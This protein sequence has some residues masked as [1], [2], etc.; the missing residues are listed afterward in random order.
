MQGERL[1][2]P[3]GQ[4]AASRLIDAV[5]PLLQALHGPK[6]I[7]IFQRAPCMM[8]RTAHLQTILLRQIAQYPRTLLSKAALHNDAVTRV[9]HQRPPEPHGA[10]YYVQQALAHAQPAA[11]KLLQHS[12]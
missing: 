4:R 7:T 3:P 6:S 9:G 12:L 5:H 2:Q 8:Q 1:F 11:H 10:R